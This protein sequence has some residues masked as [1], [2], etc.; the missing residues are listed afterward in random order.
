VRRHI[1]LSPVVTILLSFGVAAC[2]RVPSSAYEWNPVLKG[3]KGDI[4][5]VVRNLPF[6]NESYRVQYPRKEGRAVL[7]NADALFPFVDDPSL[8]SEDE[9]PYTWTRVLYEKNRSAERSQGSAPPYAFVYGAVLK[10]GHAPQAAKDTSYSRSPGFLS[11]DM[12]RRL[13]FDMCRVDGLLLP[14]EQAKVY[15]AQ[16]KMSFGMGVLGAIAAHV[17]PNVQYLDLVYSRR[18]LRLELVVRDETEYGDCGTASSPD[19]LP[20]VSG[21]RDSA[22]WQKILGALEGMGFKDLALHRQD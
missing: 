3:A 14:Q 13:T 19:I 16:G 2:S 8:A 12:Q 9:R 18:N 5:A 6:G 4:D 20:A 11:G 21:K 7:S 15:L 17:G 1:S 22:A 10:E